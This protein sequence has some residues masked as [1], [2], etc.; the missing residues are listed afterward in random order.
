M[1]RTLR[2]I[3]AAYNKIARVYDLMNRL[4]F[5][6]K[7][8]KFRSFLVARL[9]LKPG[10]T[11]L[12]LC[13]GTGL[14]FS[15]LRQKINNHGL[16]VG[17][18]I[19]SKMLQQAKV[20]NGSNGLYFLNADAASLAFRDE[21]FDAGL[22][23]FCLK[24][25]PTYKQAIGEV[26]RVLKSSGKLGILINSRFTGLLTPFGVV[27]SKILSVMAKINFELD[28]ILHLSEKF[29]I[30][31]DKRIFGGLVRFVVGVKLQ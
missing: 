16:V 10:A 6:G 13:C 20:K 22:L 11:V 15:L 9:S 7:D 24:I 17:V 1:V 12:D 14:N 18:D 5:F 3:A 26:S 30:I 2:T 31:E 21:I 25:T 4:Y 27:M 19:S 29:R 28:L 8:K 23:T